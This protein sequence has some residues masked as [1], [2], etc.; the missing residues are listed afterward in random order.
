M[1]LLSV[2][3]S[4]SGEPSVMPI[5]DIDIGKDFA[6]NIGGRYP[7]H[8]PFSGEKFREDML[9]PA[10]QRAER[11]NISLDSIS[12]YSPSF[13]EEA[14]GGVVRKLGPTVIPRLGFITTTRQYLLPKIARWMS[15]ASKEYRSS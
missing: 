13:F 11:V 8:G 12:G 1:E 14:F 4:G 9:I 5:V 6:A 3:R 2:Y 7:Q 10:L 15:D